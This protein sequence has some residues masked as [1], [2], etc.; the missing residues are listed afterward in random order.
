MKRI[1]IFLSLFSL[2]FAGFDESYYKLSN[3]ERRAVFFAKMDKL[4]DRSFAKVAKE[5]AFVK[6]FLENG[7][8]K[9]F[10]ESEGLIKLAN[11]RE[12]YRVKNLFSWEEYDKKMR[13]VPK[14]LAMAQA[15]IES[16]TATSRFA[17]KANNLFGEWTWG[18]K[19]IVPEN[20]APN[21]KHKI[22]IFDSLEESVDSYVL[23]LNRHFAYEN[24]R[25]KRYEFAKEGKEFSGIE[26]AKSLHS[27]SELG[28]SYIKMVTQVIQKYKLM[29]YDLK[30]QSPLIKW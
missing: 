11:L 20:R 23:N 1:I 22:R 25:K 29:E 15:L 2:A 5:R 14:S 16:A 4:L 8:K 10:R 9:G 24:F 26:A 30:T 28:G 27:Y 19:G 18:E 7:A 12:K 21:S 17:R 3:E 6:F 13:L